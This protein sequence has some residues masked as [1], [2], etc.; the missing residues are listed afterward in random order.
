MH[1]NFIGKPLFTRGDG[2]AADGGQRYPR[3]CIRHQ[4]STDHP[5][6]LLVFGA[7]RRQWIT[8]M[9]ARLQGFDAVLSPTVP[10]VAPPI[11]SVL[12]DDAEFFRVNGLLLRNTAVVNMLDGCGISLPCHAPDQLPVGLMLWHA[13]MHDDAVLDTALQ[14]EAVLQRSHQ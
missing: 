12:H 2:I 10:I 4:C 13:A 6:K 9:E 14:V 5:F 7:A 8:R 11:S 3:G 1:Q